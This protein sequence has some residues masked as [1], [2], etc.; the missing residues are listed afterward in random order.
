MPSGAGSAKFQPSASPPPDPN[1]ESLPTTEPARDG[2]VSYQSNDDVKQLLQTNRPRIYR[3]MSW[4]VL[5][6]A[7][8]AVFAGD[9]PQYRG[10]NHD[11]ISTEVIRTNWSQEVPREVWKIGL[12]PGLSSISVS[13]GKAFTLVRTPGAQ[14]TTEYCLA[15][16]AGTGATLWKTPVG[17]ANYPSGGVG[18]GS[19]DGPRSTPTVEGE[20]VYVL[21]SYLNLVCLNVADGEVVWSNNIVAAY[22]GTVIPWQSAASPLLEGDLVFVHCSAAASDHHLLAFHKLDGLE[23]W[24]GPNDQVANSRMTQATP[25][26]ATIASVRQVIFFAQS[27]LVSV[28]P[29]SG[30]VLWRYPF[31]YSVSTA[32]SPVVGEGVVYCSAAYGM[33]AG[34]IRIDGAGGQLSA[35]E[36]WRITGDNQNHWATPIYFDGHLYGMYGQ[37][38]ISLECLEL[39]T[40]TSQWAQGGFGY[41]SVLLVKDLILATSESGDVV[42]VRPDP[43]AYV[44]LARYRALDGSKSSIP[45]LGVRSWNVPAIS[46][47]RI[48]LRSTT[49]AVC[50][51]V[52]P[53]PPTNSPPEAPANLSPADKA[54]NQSLVLTLQASAFRDPDGDSHAS[55]QWIIRRSSDGAPVFDSGSDTNNKT[56]LTVP[57]GVLSWSTTFTWSVRYADDKSAVGPF[58]AATS[59]T[60]QAAPPLRLLGALVAGTGLFQLVID[61]GDGTVLDTNR[62]PNINILTATDLSSGLAGWAPWAGAGVLSNGKLLLEV[63]EIGGTAQRFFRVEERR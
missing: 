12:E 61:A 51:D 27:G 23:A 1:Q 39:N 17:V 50:L 53:P 22:G 44:E 3:P 19:D 60:T 29:E 25:V 59:F 48:Y 11:G 35:G 38:E 7:F 63:P 58:S 40:G 54:T 57:A 31:S 49:E 56:S 37:S 14:P 45:G 33:G 26:A 47:G 46:D 24:H 43:S 4:A 8:S 62:V 32:A 42:L 20:R 41:G 18:N 52:A 16:D 10:P 21:A 5:A 28:V 15:L 30:S 36:L 9:W 2:V 34:A 6:L 55:S 13:G